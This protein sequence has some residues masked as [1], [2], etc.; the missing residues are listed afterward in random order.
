MSG[1]S[2]YRRQTGKHCRSIINRAIS[3]EPSTGNHLK[4][5]YCETLVDFLLKGHSV[6]PY[7]LLVIMSDDLSH[8]LSILLEEPVPDCRSS[9]TGDTKLDKREGRLTPSPGDAGHPTLQDQRLALPQV[10]ARVVGDP[11]IESC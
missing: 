8:L 3:N 9:L 1:R 6:I 11:D 7:D 4:F 10:V 5:I 2:I